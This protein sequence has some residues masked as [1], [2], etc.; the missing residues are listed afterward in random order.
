M[1]MTTTDR[2]IEAAIVH[3]A[4]GTVN[5]AVYLRDRDG[6]RLLEFCNVSDVGAG[7]ALTRAHAQQHAIPEEF[8]SIRHKN[9]Y[10]AP[11]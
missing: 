1:P 7:E 2:W 4:D 6:Q 11:R 3:F 9:R 5:V 8:V 10:R